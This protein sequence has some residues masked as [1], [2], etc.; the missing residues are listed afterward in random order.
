M[1]GS[2]LDDAGE[3]P[4]PALRMDTSAADLAVRSAAARRSLLAFTAEE[5]K[6]V[7]KNPVPHLGLVLV[8]RAQYRHHRDADIQHEDGYHCGRESGS[9]DHRRL[10]RDQ[11]MTKQ[12]F[13]RTAPLLEREACPTGGSGGSPPA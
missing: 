9:P 13:Q 11:R 10:G 4:Q 7:M 8:F 6:Q 2:C 5:F 1:Q 12:G 3:P